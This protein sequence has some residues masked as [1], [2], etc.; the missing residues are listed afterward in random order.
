MRK[1]LQA[2]PSVGYVSGDYASRTTESCADH[3][4]KCALGKG[5]VPHFL[6]RSHV[7]HGMP[8]A[9]MKKTIIETLDGERFIPVPSSTALCIDVCGHV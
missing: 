2:G 9:T 3:E 6:G 8:K 1:V 7:V 4:G 5:D